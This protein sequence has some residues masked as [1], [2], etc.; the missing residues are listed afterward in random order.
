MPIRRNLLVSDLDLWIQH[1][2]SDGIRVIWI[3]YL[4][5]AKIRYHCLMLAI[6]GLS[7]KPDALNLTIVLT[8]V[9]FVYVQNVT[10]CP[11][12]ILA[13]LNK[14]NRISGWRLTG[15]CERVVRLCADGAKSCQKQDRDEV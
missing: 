14:V 4:N 15:I 13:N 5:K 10:I 12:R 7:H 1:R 8:V 2:Q 3:Y 6:F 11:R 9:T